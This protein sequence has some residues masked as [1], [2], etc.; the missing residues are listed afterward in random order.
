MTDTSYNAPNVSPVHVSLNTDSETDFW[1][2]FASGLLLTHVILKPSKKPLGLSHDMLI[3]PW[4]DCWATTLQGAATT[5]ERES[6]WW[7]FGWFFCS[8]QS[9]WWKFG[10]FFCNSLSNY[11]QNVI[12]YLYIRQTVNRMELGK[13]NP[14]TILFKFEHWFMDIIL[15][16]FSKHSLKSKRILNNTVF[17]IYFMGPLDKKSLLIGAVAWQAMIH[18]LNLW[19]LNAWRQ[20]STTWP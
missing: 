10:W 18:Y 13:T 8:R 16:I 6:N 12:P 3:S 14:A 5:V 19:W 9:N 15:L 4:P 20:I 1:T 7:K 11:L 17:E 2:S